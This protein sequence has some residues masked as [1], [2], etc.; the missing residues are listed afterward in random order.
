[1]AEGL[2]PKATLPHQVGALACAAAALAAL[3]ACGT[4][5]ELRPKPGSPVPEPSV[6]PSPSTGAE[7]P[8]AEAT[9]PGETA[10]VSPLPSFAEEYATPCSGYPTAHQ[11]MALVRQSG[12]LLPRTGS[13]TVVKGPLCAGS[14]QYTIF[15]VPQKEP[16]QV[17]SRGT[18]GN[19]TLVTAGTDICSIEVRTA[20]PVG[21]RNA[22]LCPATGT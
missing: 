18:P 19:L 8:T 20:G 2:V 15:S 5:P 22:A 3:A 9:P 13:V 21:I 17:V 10:A 6:L 4:P 12:G 11:V 1:L 16:L 14:W 7:P